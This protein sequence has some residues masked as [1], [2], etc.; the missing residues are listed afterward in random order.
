MRDAILHGARSN[1]PKL[2]SCGGCVVLRRRGVSTIDW[3]VAVRRPGEPT[4][5][6]QRGVQ[7][8][9]RGPRGFHLRP[10]GELESRLPR[11]GHVFN[12]ARS[13]KANQRQSR[14]TAPVAA[15]N[16]GGAGAADWRAGRGAA[17]EVLDVWVAETECFTTFRRSVTEG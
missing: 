10:V 7:S 13:G 15:T 14:A 11:L 1:Q 3:K 16:R 2:R 17:S 8:Y 9:L 4:P 12:G 5:E 6:R